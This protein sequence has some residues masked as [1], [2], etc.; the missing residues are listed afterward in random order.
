MIRIEGLS[1]N[2]GSVTAVYGVNLEIKDGEIFG[3]LGPNGAGKTTTMRMLSC[4]IKPTSGMAWIDDK[5]VGTGDETVDIR[6]DVGFLPEFHG[7]YENLSIY[8][9]LDFYAQ[10]YDVPP[11]SREAKIKEGLRLVGLW[12]RRDQS[13]GAMS[14]GMKQ[15]I[16]IVRALV[17]DPKYL[18]LDEPTASL[19]PEASKIVRD[20]IAELRK[21]GR[22]ILIN[23][24]N[25]AEAERLC[26]R[27]GILKTRI[28]AVDSPSNL[29]RHHFKRRVEVRAQGVTGDIL[30][31]LKELP[32]VKDLTVEGKSII[33]DMENPEE[34]NPRIAE[35]LVKSGAKLQFMSEV[36][37]SLEDVYLKLIKGVG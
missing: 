14:K 4:L 26:D 2:F 15:K 18:F 9:N 13:V 31:G 36:K 37:H 8:R 5:E 19:D 12:E 22:T 35:F 27:V 3:L 20:F 30:N 32:F 25:L 6:K 33:I 7:L 28:L 17:H 10:L 23:T 16:A 24:H 1:K 21:E 11:G 29:E 34:N